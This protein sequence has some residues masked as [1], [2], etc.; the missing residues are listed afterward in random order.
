MLWHEKPLRAGDH[1]L[2][3]PITKP[4]TIEALSPACD[5]GAVF[6]QLDVDI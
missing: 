5:T 6:L 2:P 3:T 4:P 1:E